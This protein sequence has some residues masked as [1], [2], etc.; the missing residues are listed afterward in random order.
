MNLHR[1]RLLT[2]GCLLLALGSL[3]PAA[4]PPTTITYFWSNGRQVRVAVVPNAVA[5]EGPSAASRAVDDPVFRELAPQDPSEVARAA[6]LNARGV[7][8]VK[9]RAG[10]TAE[11]RSVLRRSGTAR[12][13]GVAVDVG[14]QTKARRPYAVLTP[15]FIVRFRRGVTRSAIDEINKKL[16]A[17]IVREDPFVENQF[18][19]RVA[20]G[21]A[22]RSLELS[23]QYFKLPQVD[24]LSHPNFIY[25]RETRSDPNDPLWPQ[26]W[27]LSTIDAPAAWK[28]TRGEEVI[29][30]V[31][32]LEGVEIKHEDLFP[33]RFINA[34][35]IPDNNVDDDKNG[36][37]DDVNGWNFRSRSNDPKLLLP[38]GTA[39]AAVAVAA[40]DNALGGC[41][42][43]PK[44]RLLPVAQGLTVQ[45]DADAF[46]YAMQMGAGVIS[47]SWG[48][49]IGLPSTQVVEEAIA[50]VITQ[51]RSGLGTAVV[52]AMTNQKRDN[53]SAGPD[54]TRD[55]ASV[56]GVLAIGRSTDTDKWGESGFGQGM[57]LLAPTN[58]ARGDATAGCLPDNLIGTREIVTADLMGPA[59]YN[60]GTPKP[61]FCNAKASEI[62]NQN[63]TGCFQGTSS[64]TPLVAGVVALMIAANPKITVPAI[65]DILAETAE[66]IEP[67]VGAYKPDDRGRLYSVTHGW[68]RV[69]AARAVV[70]AAAWMPQTT[71]P[72]APPP[73][74]LAPSPEGNRGITRQGGD[75]KVAG[76]DS[77]EVRVPS[78]SGSRSAY[79]WEDAT[80]LVIKPGESTS[81]VLSALE[82]TAKLVSGFSWT[83][84]LM[85][86]NVIVVEPTGAGAAERIADLHARGLV[87]GT[88][89]VAFFDK[90]GKNVAVLLNRFSIQ[91]ADGVR[92]P[93]LVAEAARYGFNL[94]SRPGGRYE[95]APQ[96]ATR[97]AL[98]AAERAQ[99]FA[100]SPLVK[101]DSLRLEWI[102]PAERR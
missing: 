8:I 6:S 43:A 22:G 91:P 62:G 69:H 39:A 78:T 4:Q 13:L 42:V 40:C 58:A 3:P 72:P 33:N 67:A 35:E 90:G 20:D 18:V 60:E 19:L 31:I 82:G 52:F 89:R 81:T 71:P 96:A 94:E 64:A 87:E 101:P 14:P 44:A 102:V 93:E 55:I 30:A 47:N 11:L 49:P 10:R 48:Y 80:A 41:G 26:Q 32:D 23:D 79:V 29:V 95:L 45:D 37:V 46:R 9:A 68:G 61:C 56:P 74:P 38:H 59:G 5:I 54:G 16:G 21:S 12:E 83:Q 28:V 50:D 88:G 97:D 51:G 84:D 76:K 15:E 7:I 65:R 66:R 98:E 24:G 27:H 86:R 25:P 92:E 73:P 77:S 100:K 1:P 57:A 99:L 75:V 70:A 17:A 2:L 36:M 34:K 53:F 63:Y 85:N